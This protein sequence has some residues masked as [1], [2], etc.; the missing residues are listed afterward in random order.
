MKTRSQILTPSIPW[1]RKFGTKLGWAVTLS[2][3]ISLVTMGV[4]LISI[5]QNNQKRLIQAF[6]IRN[7]N[8]VARLVSDH[9]HSAI[10]NMYFYADL[11]SLIDKEPQEQKQ[12]LEYVLINRSNAFSELALLDAEGKEIVKVSESYT[13]LPKELGDLS[14]TEMF[15]TVKRGEVFVGPFYSQ[16]DGGRLSIPIAIPLSS[17]N[18]KIVSVLTADIN[19]ARLWKTIAKV[20]IGKTGYAYIVDGAGR[21]MAHQNPARVLEQHG[22]DL[23]HF[24][25][26]AEFIQ[27]NI[28]PEHLSHEYDGL[29]AKPVIGEYVSI[30]ATPWAVV[31]EMPTQ[32]AFASL[33]LMT[34]Y[35]IGLVLLGVLVTTTLSFL[36]L[37]RPMRAIN[38]LSANAV[39]ISR[40]DLD[41]SLSITGDDEIS[42]LAHAFNS[43][44]S[45]LRTLIGSLE[46]TIA[47]QKETEQALRGSEE[48]FRTLADSLPQIVFETDAVGTLTFV[49]QN[50]YEIFGY[51]REEVEAGVS[52]LDTLEPGDEERALA[53]MAKVLEG[54]SLGGLEYTALKKNG[55]RFPVMIHSARI[56]K[57]GVPVGM[58]GIIVD[59]TEQKINEKKLSN[60]LAFAE[61]IVSESPVGILLYEPGGQ[62][63]TANQSAADMVGGTREQILSLNFHQIQSW[64]QMGLYEVAMRVFKDKTPL[65]HALKGISTYGQEMIM[66]AQL[67]PFT[68]EE[69][70]H[71]LLML[72]DMRE[73]EKAQDEVKHLRNLLSNIVNSMPSVLV[74]VDPQGMV[75]QWNLEAEKV[76]GISAEQAQS[77]SLTDVFPQLAREMGKVR[78]AI[79]ERTPKTEARIPSQVDG[80]VHFADV[81]VFPL[82]AN[83]IQGAV[84]RMDDVTDRVRIEEMMIQSEKMLSVGGLAAG[85]A[86][87]INNPLAGIIQNAQVLKNRTVEMTE[88]NQAVAEECGASMEAIHRYMEKRGLIRMLDSI[89][90][91]GVRAGKIVANMLSF[92]RKSETDGSSHSINDI[93]ENTLELASSDYDLKKRFDFKQIQIIREYDP[94]NPHVWCQISKIQQVLLNLLRNAA[95][96][97]AEGENTCENPAITLRTAQENQ[98]VRI[99]VEDNGPGMDEKTRKRVFEPFFT[100]KSVGTGTGLGLS[101]SYFIIAED[102]GGSMTVE[103]KSGK[104]ARFIIHLPQN[105]P[106]F[107]SPS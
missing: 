4:G 98:R 78:E 70:N 47:Q 23:S 14:R 101:V 48:R 27:N 24:P 81:T 65:R 103:S 41:R 102:H 30:P 61:K 22:R 36:V 71:L 56:V 99:E 62:C 37:R 33:R 25:P 35:L 43:M 66:D 50:A 87:E 94:A 29:D 42:A 26:V 9:I 69:K 83:G 11:V 6:Q 82:I 2:M 91:S 92:S 19:V 5:S 73:Q 86:H 52:A 58:R 38:R 46:Q 107:T 64:K 85:M 95:H 72:S 53:N 77:R 44:T 54:H 39:A 12:A 100:T 34:Y 93:M 105:P 7:A 97:M 17:R 57:N 68:I 31:V 55:S 96:A 20:E 28:Y 67:V 84:I 15:A 8:E 79:A 59:L 40:G 74:G 45:Q 106:E 49:N 13:Y 10:T 90:S 1:R 63:M 51:S 76:T 3:V 80:E 16:A 60:A 21:L 89:H 104:G 32:E 18:G 75:T 88:K